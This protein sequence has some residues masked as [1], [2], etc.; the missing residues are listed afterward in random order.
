M[1]DGKFPTESVDNANANVAAYKKNIS[2]Y[3]LC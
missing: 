1:V 3:L 2:V